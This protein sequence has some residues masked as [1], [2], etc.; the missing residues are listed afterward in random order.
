MTLNIIG[1]LQH[2]ILS[3]V[4]GIKALSVSQD[5]LSESLSR[6]YN[7]LEAQ[8]E[9]QKTEVLEGLQ[10]QRSETSLDFA[11]LESRVHSQQQ[12][13]DEL[14]SRMS[15]AVASPDILGRM[16]RAEL[17]QQLQPLLHRFADVT[18][19]IDQIALEV[20]KKASE[21]SDYKA[22][23]SGATHGLLDPGSERRDVYIWVTTY[24]VRGSQD[25]YFRLK[26]VFKPRPWLCS[27]GIS[28]VFSSGPDEFGHYSICPS[29]LPIQIIPY[30]SP[31]WDIFERDDAFAVR[32]L[33]E[34][35]RNAEHDIES[36]REILKLLR[37]YSDSGD[38]TGNGSE[39]AWNNIFY[40]RRMSFEQQKSYWHLFLEYGAI[41]RPFRWRGNDDMEKNK[42]LL[43]FYL[44]AGGDPN[45]FDEDGYPLLLCALLL[46]PDGN[47]KPDISLV[48]ILISAGADIYYIHDTDNDPQNAQTITDFAFEFE[49]EDLW[50]TA[51]NACGLDF[52][53]VYVE[54]VRRLQD[55]RRLRGATRSGVD[56]ESI[57]GLGPSSELRQRAGHAGRRCEE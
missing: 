40:S 57:T 1:R 28:T 30:S 20:S 26:F 34:H 41:L 53:S 17:R 39:F 48:T 50:E 23:R 7:A 25:G 56:V 22:G 52:T 15:S 9:G 47:T 43:N 36:T 33:V 32:Q 49:A 14:S 46:L 6:R 38:D 16:V 44:D 10:Y 4:D 37:D 19:L 13:L 2:N 45:Q 54:S 21:P 18:L 8:L 51:L 11:S 29:I 55:H 5:A 3:A 27:T 12:S 35:D 31:V 24:R 42:S